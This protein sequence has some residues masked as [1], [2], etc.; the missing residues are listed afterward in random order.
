MLFHLVPS[1]SKLDKNWPVDGHFVYKGV[2]G[3]FITYWRGTLCHTECLFSLVSVVLFMSLTF[4]FKHKN[5]SV[6]KECAK[7]TVNKEC[8]KKVMTISISDE[9]K[10]KEQNQVLKWQQDILL[11]KT[12]TY[13]SLI[14]TKG[15]LH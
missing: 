4:I 2:Q 11:F 8:A 12:T 13:I 14:G 3:A 7:K 10:A 6:N 1:F 5:I 9:E 15:I